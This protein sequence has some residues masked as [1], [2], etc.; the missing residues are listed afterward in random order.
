MQGTQ[1]SLCG[2]HTVLAVCAAIDQQTA[3]CSL[4]A[5]RV[6]WHC[7]IAIATGTGRRARRLSRKGRGIM[8]CM[9]PCCSLL[10]ARAGT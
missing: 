7:A 10:Q 9:S 8:H 2:P 1:R 3:R 4:S 6:G 5:A